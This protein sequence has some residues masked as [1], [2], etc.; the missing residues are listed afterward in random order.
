MFKRFALL[1]L[2]L[3]LFIFGVYLAGISGSVYGGD[4]GDVILAAFFG[5]VA[6]PP[7][8]PLNSI[9][10]YFF[11]HLPIAASVAYKANIMMA[12]FSAGTIVF[13]FLILKILYKNV[14][15]ALCAS[16]VLAFSPLFWLYAHVT[17]VFQLNL[18]LISASVYFLVLWYKEK[19]NRNLFVSVFLLGLAV[20][21]HQ[22]AVLLIPCYL[23]LMY[24]TDRKMFRLS[25]LSFSLGLTF[26]LGAIPYIFVPLMAARQTPINWDNAV[27]IP[28]L[29]QLLSRADYG[30]FAASS[31]F[32]G[33]GYQARL[34]QV[35]SYFAF[36]KNDF[37]IF[38]SLLILLGAFYTFLKER[39]M[40]W[41]LFLAVFFTGPFFLFYSSFS[42]SSDFL[43]GIWERFILLNY[44]FLAVFL[45][46]G[47]YFIYFKVRKV[48]WR[49]L[50][51]PVRNEVFLI[52]I[53]LSFLLFPLY[54]SVHNW[55]KADMSKF[56]LGDWLGNDVL[57]SSSYNSI[58]FMF[59][60]TAVFN[61]QYVY[62]TSG[63]FTDRKII[64]G[65][66][67]R[68]LFYRQQLARE[69][70]QL[71]YPESFLTNS[72]LGNGDYIN[73]LI[74]ANIDK[75]PIY[76]AQFTPKVQGYAWTNSGLLKKLVKNETI[77]NK[78]YLKD[79][80]DTAFSGFQINVDE[81]NSG[82]T[83]FIPL[84]I[85]RYYAFSY[86]DSGDEMFGLSFY[87]EAVGYYLLAIKINNDDVRAYLGLARSS[88]ALGDCQ[89]AENYSTAAFNFGKNDYHTFNVLSEVAKKCQNNDNLAQE[90]MRRADHLKKSQS[91][92][93]I[94]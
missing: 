26:L 41:F 59:D 45:G 12:L 53:L 68:H 10:G 72:N 74:A 14:L 57:T 38:G 66:I 6:H 89:N 2:S 39:M 92:E 30:T 71:K 46:Y 87:K 25:K 65:G 50:G 20:F 13:L 69:Y 73:G 34:L 29:I 90:Y 7:G 11:T 43:F 88:V 22:T 56:K 52:I 32:V 4:S 21:Y 79:V 16:L 5:G 81:A 60:D 86:D 75:F 35:V 3:F 93:L 49:K 28:N 58:I 80:N 33:T 64:I 47:L 42:L 23:Y 19:A 61:T 55:Q 37:T 76:S 40:F 31:S 51:L 84:S 83:N 18:L 36:A 94:N 70:P 63:Q 15:I 82:Y 1:P 62:Y 85:K 8:Y 24:R 17:E 9:L 91:E 48:G 44:L 67:L 77:E 27:N 78:E 54:M